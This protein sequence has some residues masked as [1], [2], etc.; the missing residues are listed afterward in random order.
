[1]EQIKLVAC[2]RDNHFEIQISKHFRMTYLWK[3]HLTKD[4][5]DIHIVE[6]SFIL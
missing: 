6:I 5:L 2:D 3:A 4:N 1:M